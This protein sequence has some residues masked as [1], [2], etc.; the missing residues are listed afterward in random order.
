VVGVWAGLALA[1]C[2][3]TDAEPFEPAA[4]D[5]A[6]G[7]FWALTVDHEIATLS[8]AAPYN[9]LQLTATPRDANGNPLQGLGPAAFRSDAPQLA[10][11]DANGLVTALAPGASIVVI[12][13]LAAGAVRHTDTV[14][15]DVT[16]ETDPPMVTEFS[17]LPQPPDSASW[18]MSG[19][20]TLFFLDNQG[21]GTSIAAKFYVPTALDAAGNPIPDL[22][23]V[24]RS[25]DTTVFRTFSTPP[26]VAIEGRRPGRARLYATTT[27]Y[28][29]TM[30]DTVEF[31]I[32]MPT[33]AVVR[34]QPDPRDPAR[35][36]FAPSDLSVAPGGTIVWTNVTGQP[37]DIVFDDPTN[38]IEHG[39]ASCAAAGGGV[40]DAGGVGD[41]PP[42]G[43]P[44][45]PAAGL[46]VEN[47]R[48]R[49][50]PAP[51]VYS[52]SSPLIGA[53]GRIVVETGVEE[54]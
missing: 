39:T 34:V 54:P 51:G 1:A 36:V 20:G 12:A 19:D 48:S 30:A 43:V 16:T 2:G 41:I 52:Y 21:A 22:V 45:D 29:T 35:L 49:R 6:A 8:T 31:T 27:R 10:Q 14:F 4:G 9:T 5:G 13:E 47:C 46:H 18:S 50:F 7:L 44:Q 24:Y 33:H 42:F 28:G 17:I 15:I 23:P 38:V 26:L 32:T 11:V 3:G 40:V 37:V 53:T 25:S